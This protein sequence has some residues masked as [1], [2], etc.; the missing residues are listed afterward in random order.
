[1]GDLLEGHSICPELAK[2]F[3]GMRRVSAEHFVVR[4]AARGGVFF[5]RNVKGYLA[6]DLLK[7]LPPTGV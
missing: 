1:M 5:K 7:T 6:T 4:Y 2:R 3:C